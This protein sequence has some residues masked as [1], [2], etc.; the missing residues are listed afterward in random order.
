MQLKIL[1]NR[2][3]PVKRFVY[4]KM[5]LVAEPEQPNGVGLEVHIR[6]RQGSRGICGGCGQPGPGYDHHCQ[7]ELGHDEGIANPAPH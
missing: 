3:H 6:P 7:S 1:L 5:Q 2:V 4:E